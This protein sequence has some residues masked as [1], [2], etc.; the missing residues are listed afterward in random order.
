MKIKPPKGTMIVAGSNLACEETYLANLESERQPQLIVNPK[1]TF[2]LIGHST[3]K[4][5]LI[6]NTPPFPWSLHFQV[7]VNSKHTPPFLLVA[8]LSSVCEF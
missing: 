3:F 2:I 8:P 4:C 1:H 6:L 5:F 7:F